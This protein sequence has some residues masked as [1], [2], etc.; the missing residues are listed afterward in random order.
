MVIGRIVNLYPSS[1]NNHLY[2]NYVLRTKAG[3]QHL[4]NIPAQL[5]PYGFVPVEYRPLIEAL[6]LEFPVRIIPVPSDTAYFVDSDKAILRVE[7][8]LPEELFQLYRAL[9]AEGYTDC[10]EMDWPFKLRHM[11]NMGYGV[12]IEISETKKGVLPVTD[13]VTLADLP[14]YRWV[15]MSMVIDDGFNMLDYKQTRILVVRA[16]DGQTGEAVEFRDDSEFP[17]EL[18]LLKRLIRF[19]KTYDFPISWTNFEPMF[20]ARRCKHLGIP[21]DLKEWTWLSMQNVVMKH[22]PSMAR[23]NLLELE[24]F[25]REVLGQTK[26]N[27]VQEYYETYRKAP[28]QL[29][30]Y[31][32]EEVHLMYTANCKLKIIEMEFLLAEL[33]GVPVE[34]LDRPSRMVTKRAIDKALIHS[35]RCLWRSRIKQ[36][37]PP[38]EGPITLDPRQGFYR[39]VAILDYFSLFNC[40]MQIWGISPEQWNPRSQKFDRF[41]HEPGIFVEILE[42]YTQKLEEFKQLRNAAQTADEW[43]QYE[44]FRKALKPPIL[45]LW[46]VIASRRNRFFRREVAELIVARARELLLLAVDYIQNLAHIDVIYGDVDSVMIS[47]PATWSPQRCVREAEKLA[48]EITHMIQRKLHA[49]GLLEERVNLLKLKLESLYAT[50]LLVDVKKR[51]SGARI[52]KDGKG[53]TPPEL[54]SVGHELNRTDRC[55]FVRNLQET[56]FHMIHGRVPLEEITKYLYQVKTD[57]FAGKYDED[58]VITV[59][60]AKPLSQYTKAFAP[61]RAA[62][63]LRRMG[64]YLP[65][66]KIKFVYL[67]SSQVWPVEH[68]IPKRSITRDGYKHIWENRTMTW[69]PKLLQ[70]FLSPAQLRRELEGIRSLEHFLRLGDSPLPKKAMVTSE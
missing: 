46:G 31:C 67:S 53:F 14:P 49:E 55:P 11:N 6:D 66:K 69:L 59:R 40:I 18:Q 57:L 43:E 16:I 15:F 38:I 54:H 58:L 35:R 33:L 24:E 64:R 41:P 25:A 68:G 13:P 29:S 22:K 30:V 1:D 70:P 8:N 26:S 28:E 52:W 63:T 44:H 65:H 17:N 42:E 39:N 19:L 56:V 4:A 21:F 36:R 51:Y 2:M 12:I 47:L 45:M 50:Y 61:A 9:V 62:R 20:L 7:T 10:Y 3:K 5:R 60:L 23:G 27:F 48:K 32:A 34:V 37:E